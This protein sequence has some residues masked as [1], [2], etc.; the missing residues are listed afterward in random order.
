[1]LRSNIVTAGRSAGIVVLSEKI[2]VGGSEP[3]TKTFDLGISHAANGVAGACNPDNLVVC[4]GK[5]PVQ[6]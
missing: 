2:V 6:G 4:F 5:R 1:M 3:A